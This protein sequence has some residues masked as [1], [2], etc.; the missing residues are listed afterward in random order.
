MN[1][2]RSLAGPVMMIAILLLGVLPWFL[3]NILRRWRD[4]HV[5]RVVTVGLA[6]SFQFA[7]FLWVISL[8]DRMPPVAFSRL[9]EKA[10][11]AAFLMSF[12]YVLLALAIRALRRLAGIFR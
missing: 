6:L 2:R 10:L 11:I 1:L 7:L 3:P 5:S 12:A 4:W 9:A 8:T